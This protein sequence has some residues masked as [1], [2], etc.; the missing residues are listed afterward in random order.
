MKT[1]IKF[2]ALPLILAALAATLSGATAFAA[3]P[4]H[5]LYV[6][7]AITKNYVVGAK[8]A[9]KSGILQR[10]GEGDYRHIG[11]NFPFF[12][13]ISFDPRNHDVFYAATLNG[14]I[15]TADGGKTWRVST[16]WDITEPK[17]VF[18]DP[19]APDTIYLALPDGIAVSTDRGATWSRRENGL[20]GRGKY[21][22]VVKVD[23]AKAGRAIAGCETGIYITDNAAKNWRRVFATTDTVTDI[24]QSPRD[25][26]LWL[27]STQSAGTLVSRDGG[28]TW[29]KFAG[30]PSADALYNIAFDAT[31]PLR[32]AIGSWTYGVYVT[33]DGGK[34]WTTRND[35]LPDGHCVFRVGIDPDTGRLYAAIYKDFI[36]ASDDFGRT[37]RKDGLEGST[38]YNFIFVPKTETAAPAK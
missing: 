17:D 20:P 4:A 6:C 10:A 1:K 18:V 3:A 29:E 22:Q 12:F 34:T 30:V 38:V 35:G 9:D 25:P 5:D 21:T 13:N 26:K 2:P 36:Y 14:C 23:R 37:W 24:Q 7:A 28:V 8:L 33:E 32:H 31:N 27:A 16:G 15:Q 11:Q 19:N